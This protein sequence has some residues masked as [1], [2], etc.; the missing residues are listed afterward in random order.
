MKK[1]LAI[2]LLA[3]VAVSAAETLTK[4]D[5][6]KA[7]AELEGSR[8]VFLDATK[9]LSPAQWNFKP[10]PERWSAAECAQHIAMSE[11][12]IFGVVREKVMKS[13]PTPEKRDA[14]KG[15]DDT[16]VK[17]LQDRSHKATAPEPIDPTKQP[18]APADSVKLF[19]DSR[20]RTIDYMKTTQDDLRDHFFDHPA[21]AIGTLDGYQ[22][23]M[24]IS[25]HTRRHTLQILE[26]KADP[27][28]PKN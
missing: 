5:R 2:F 27:N 10:S 9:D 11:N 17:M 24:L 15:K 1:W 6:D 12:F 28:F 20:V 3:A 18:M 26:V 16:L 21:P 14:V 7:V 25:G 23:I 22:W 4:A 8:Q 13:P 19:L